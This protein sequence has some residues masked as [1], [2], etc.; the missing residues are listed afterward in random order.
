MTSIT[1][2]TEQ[3]TWPLRVVC[4][5]FFLI[6]CICVKKQLLTD[7]QM[8]SELSRV[9]VLEEDLMQQLMRDEIHVGARA[10]PRLRGSAVAEADLPSTNLFYE[11]NLFS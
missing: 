7:L 8:V 1:P 6:N 3:L 4:T 9:P 5:I 2:L 10:R 11:G